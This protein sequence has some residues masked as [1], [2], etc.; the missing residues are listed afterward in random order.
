MKNTKFPRIAFI[1]SYV[2]GIALA[3]WR[4][5]ILKSYYNFETTGFTVEADSGLADMRFILFVLAAVVL[6][7]TFFFNKKIKDNE[8]YGK[9]YLS[10]SRYTQVERIVST[11]VAALIQ[12]AVIAILINIKD[13]IKLN[14]AIAKLPTISFVFSLSVILTVIFAEASAVTA[15]I[16][17]VTKKAAEA[18]SCIFPILTAISAAIC[19]QMNPYFTLRNSNRILI[20][21]AIVCIVLCGLFDMRTRIGRG[22]YALHLGFGCFATIV[23]V[24]AYLPELIFIVIGKMSINVTEACDMVMMIVLACELITMWRMTAIGK[25]AGTVVDPQEDK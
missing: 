5:F 19:N 10:V 20:N 12:A 3:I 6:I 4:A 24:A 13:A 14:T 21:V 17:T 8:L 9:D 25:D 7:V 16:R 18:S 11:V 15:V 22:S 23:G 1:I 2:I